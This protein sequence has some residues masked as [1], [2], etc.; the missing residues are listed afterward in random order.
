MLDKK[1]HDKQVYFELSMGN[2]GNSLDGHNES[3]TI[4]TG[5]EGE[6]L[7]AIDV[8]T[9]NSTTNSCK[10]ISHDK[11]HY[12]LPYWDYKQ[13]THVRCTFPDL[14]RRMYNSNMIAKIAEKFEEGLLETHQAL[15]RDDPISEVKVHAITLHDPVFK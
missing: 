13:C 11:S 2:A 3:H 6:E 14:R 8:T 5:E 15:E 9:F 12:F 10:P 7:D 1:L 4:I